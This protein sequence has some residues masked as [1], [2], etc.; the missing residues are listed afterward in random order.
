MPI[1]VGSFA[2]SLIMLALF[3]GNPQVNT[4]QADIGF[5][6]A[7]YPNGTCMRI[8]TSKFASI[9]KIESWQDGYD[10]A[11]MTRQL[12]VKN[13]WIV[14][15]TNPD[16]PMC[17]A[18]KNASTQGLYGVAVVVPPPVVPVPNPVITVG[19]TVTSLVSAEGVWTFG[20][21]TSAGGNALLLNGV[22]TGGFGKSLQLTNGKVYTFTAE[23]RWYVWNGGWQSAPAPN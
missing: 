11:E 3:G 18:V 14:Y 19:G 2:A 5:L 4:G 23:S 13:G 17:K 16:S 21:A 15:N 1:D 10:M 9:P 6:W 20:T 7:R 22:T 12:F 8:D